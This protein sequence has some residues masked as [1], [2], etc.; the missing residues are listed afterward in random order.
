MKTRIIKTGQAVLAFLLALL[1][2]SGC[3][4]M[5]RAEYGCPHA[6]YR[7]QGKV[8]DVKTKEPVKNIRVVFAYDGLESE[9]GY[10]DTLYTDDEGM[11][12]REYSS[13]TFSNSSMQVKFEDI[14]GW[15]NGLYDTKILDEQNLPVKQTEKGSGHW[16]H[17]VYTITADVELTPREPQPE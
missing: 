3:G 16:Y 2:F 8:T 10:K 14:D 5:G 7:I 1:G 9:W 6:D 12:A 11:I 15:D 4:G 13:M 17:G